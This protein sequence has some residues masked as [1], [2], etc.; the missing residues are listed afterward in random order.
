MW[1]IYI[2][3][4]SLLRTPV[5]QNPGTYFLPL[6]LHPILSISSINF[7]LKER[8]ECILLY[9]FYI[10]VININTHSLFIP[11][12][13]CV[14]CTHT[15][16]YVTWAQVLYTHSSICCWIIYSVHY[17]WLHSGYYTDRPQGFNRRDEQHRALLSWAELGWTWAQNKWELDLGISDMAQVPSKVPHLSWPVTNMR[18]EY[19]DICQSVRLWICVW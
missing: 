1:Y 6:F 2:N 16:I 11:H 7:Q 19:Q 9:L 13:V 17:S 4:C 12:K 18:F 15:F 10:Y 8:K 14:H 5:I 3:I